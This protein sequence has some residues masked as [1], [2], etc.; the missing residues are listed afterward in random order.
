MSSYLLLLRHAEAMDKSYAQKDS[1]RL[2]TPHGI[3]QLKSISKQ[4]LDKDLI[5]QLIIASPAIRALETA[6]QIIQNLGIKSSTLQTMDGL[7]SGDVYNYQ[8]IIFSFFNPAE[9]LLIIGHNPMISD[10]STSIS[11][12]S[13]YFT[14]ATLAAFQPSENTSAASF[15]LDTCL[16]P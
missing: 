3:Q 9:T 6:N 13:P 8:E 11:P 16:A 1:E 15:S 10:F 7:Y 5:P 4:M 12:K 2:L 14:T